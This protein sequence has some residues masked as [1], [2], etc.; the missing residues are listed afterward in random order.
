[1]PSCPGLTPMEHFT[2]SLTAGSVEHSPPHQWKFS[3]GGNLHFKE[4]LSPN[5]QI[6]STTIICDVPSSSETYNN[7]KMDW[8]N[9]LYFTD[10]Y[11]VTFNYDYTLSQFNEYFATYKANR[12]RPN[13][14]LPDVYQIWDEVIWL[15]P[16]KGCVIS[17]APIC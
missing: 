11:N 6:L 5:L 1:M 10:G 7:P 12:F 14:F 3:H 15:T 4:I 13:G 17:T 8:C 2:I 16:E 9:T